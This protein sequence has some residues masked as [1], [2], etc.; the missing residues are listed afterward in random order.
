MTH[1]H[2]KDESRTEQPVASECPFLTSLCR[3]ACQKQKNQHN[4]AV[5][6]LDTIEM[7]KMGSAFACRLKLKY[8]HAFLVMVR[9]TV[10]KRATRPTQCP[11]CCFGATICLYRFVYYKPDLFCSR[12]D[13][14]IRN[15][16]FALG[17]FMADK[18]PPPCLPREKRRN[19]RIFAS[20]RL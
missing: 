20:T 10:A 7:C 2:L 5:L 11:F 1:G 9:L 4:C 15:S 18:S 19:G 6:V 17:T 3:P 14:C 8:P 12:G 16:K 13:Y